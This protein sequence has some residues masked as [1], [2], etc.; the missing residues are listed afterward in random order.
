MEPLGATASIIAIIQAISACWGYYSSVKGAKDDIEG[1]QKEVESIK[2]LVKRVEEDLL[3][4]SKGPQ[5]LTSKELEDALAGCDS[6]LERLKKILTPKKQHRFSGVAA[7]AKWYFKG[8]D[9]VKIIQNLERWKQDIV[10]ALNID[11]TVQIGN[12]NQKLDCANQ[13]V[14]SANQKLDSVNQKLDFAGLPF[15]EGAAYGS[16]KDQHEPECLPNTRVKILNDIENW[17]EDPQGKCLFWLS[18]VAGTGKSTISRTVAGKLKK[19]R[20]LGASFFF[21]RGEKDRESAGKFFTTLASQ[22]AHRIDGIA[23]SVQSAIDENPTIGTMNHHEQFTKLILN[24]LLELKDRSITIIIVIDALDECDRE[25]DQSLIISLLGRLKEIRLVKV[26]VFLTSRPE[27]PLRLGFQDLPGETHQDVI[28]HEI[29]GIQEDIALFLEI[30]FAKIRGGSQSL[31]AQWPGDDT[32]QHLA[33]MAVPLFIFAATVCKFIGDP[34]WGPNEQLEVILKYQSADWHITQLEKTYLPILHQFTK[35]TGTQG[36]QLATQFRQIVGTIVNLATPLSIPSISHLLSI[37]EET[38]DRRLKPLHS[39]LDIP[40]DKNRHIPVRTFHLSFRDFLS[41]E[42]LRTNP[43][44]GEF[45]IDTTKAHQNIYEKCIALMS[46]EHDLKSGE[47]D[48]KSGEYGLKRNI[49]GLKSP[50]TLRSEVDN[51]IVRQSISQELQYACLYWVYHLEQSE[52]PVCDG[53]DLVY[54]FLQTHLLHWLE[55][56]SLMGDINAAIHMVRKLGSAV[57]SEKGKEMSAF[58]YGIQRFV[59]QNRS[60]IDLA[61]LQ[62]YSSAIIFTPQKSIVRL[63]FDLKSLAPYITQPPRVQDQWDALL[64]TLEGHTN[65]VACVAFSPN[66]T[67]LASASWDKTIGI[68][69]LATGALL[70]RLRGHGGRVNS[71]AFCADS[72]ALAPPSSDGTARVGG[73]TNGSGLRIE[74]EREGGVRGVVFSGG[75]VVASGSNDKTVR[76]WDVTTGSQLLV[77]RGHQSGVNAVVFSVDGKVLASGS[78]DGTVRIWDL[79]AGSELRVLEGHKGWVNSV[80]FS[81]DGRILASASSDKTIR[82]WDMTTKSKPRVLKGH[83][84]EV[85]AVAFSVDSSILASGSVDGTVR[86][87]D[88]IAGSELRVMKSHKGWVN[89]IGFS[90]DGRILASASSDKMIRVWEVATGSELRVLEGHTSGVLS[91]SFSANSQ[92]LASGSGDNTIRIWDAN[93]TSSREVLEGHTNY[94]ETVLFSP[95]GK[96]VASAGGDGAVMLWDPASGAPLHRIQVSEKYSPSIGFYAGGKLLAANQYRGG[97]FV[98]VDVATGSSL[99]DRDG[100]KSFAFSADGTVLALLLRWDKTILAVDAATGDMLQTFTTKDEPDSVSFSDDCQHIR[101]DE[102]TF[103]FQTNKPPAPPASS[104]TDP[105][106]I[107]HDPITIEDEWLLWGAERLLWLPNNYR[108]S[109]NYCWNVY[110]NTICIGHYSG[111][112]SFIAVENPSSHTSD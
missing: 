69:D 36:K 81:V 101:T 61:P 39:V 55:A 20:I 91:V 107:K 104:D 94:V 64:Q 86:I 25:D 1:L 97:R 99:W 53:D 83:K 18:G 89:G 66:G 27:I 15:A 51:V 14:D 110:G 3:S 17:A 44:F 103:P 62:V 108:P 28:L 50:G 2:G 76:V 10:L 40:S 23:S 38:V 6:E 21:R 35:K 47:R 34:D 24:P 42:L 100:V 80:G 105:S 72:R 33:K 31:P 57:D 112:V 75:P 46:G 71:I 30:E 37:S 41:D 111:G 68:W 4:A 90:V 13:G 95:D 109:F 5:L 60:V 59:R 85:E 65:G 12:A 73:V 98:A 22:L 19:K 49:C 74:D 88:L 79:I 102:E 84:N 70:Q 16:F 63:K 67:Q 48:P 11:Q 58:I 82:V 9:A 87:W 54:Q 8:P 26:R 96:V 106:Q 77:L 7:H 32:I 52:N 78:W 93:N 45:W 92:V 43:K 29:P 56:L